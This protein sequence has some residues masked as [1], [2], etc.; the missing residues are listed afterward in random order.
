M[1]SPVATFLNNCV[2]VCRDALRDTESAAP[3][4]SHPLF[5]DLLNF[6]VYD[7]ITADRVEGAS[8]IKPDLVGGLGLRPDDRLA[9]SP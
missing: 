6:I 3:I 4:D 5:Y 1:V 9:W 7:K 2:D 8:P